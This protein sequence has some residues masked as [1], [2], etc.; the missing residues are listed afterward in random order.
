VKS[1]KY[2]TK[3]VKGLLGIGRFKSG[4][5]IKHIQCNHC[6]ESSTQKVD[7]LGELVFKNIMAFI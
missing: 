4:I 7:P 5:K 3:S 1:K 6:L 2:L